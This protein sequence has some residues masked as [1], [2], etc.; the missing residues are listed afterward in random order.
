MTGYLHKIRLITKFHAKR[1][2]NNVYEGLSKN[3]FNQDFDS[4]VHK[5]QLPSAFSKIEQIRLE[6]L[7]LWQIE[8]IFYSFCYQYAPRVPMGVYRSGRTLRIRISRFGM[9]PSSFKEARTKKPLKKSKNSLKMPVFESFFCS[10]F[11]KI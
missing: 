10:S 9:R 4:F 8:L 11:F 5:S 7:S 1:I 3:Y 6:I 2:L